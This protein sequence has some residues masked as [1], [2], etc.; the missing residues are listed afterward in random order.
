MRPG[1]SAPA[2][3]GSRPART[4][5]R[6]TPGGSS[7]RTRRGRAPGLRA[8]HQHGEQRPQSLPQGPADSS[9]GGQLPDRVGLGHQG[10][11]LGALAQRHGLVVADERDVYTALASAAFGRSPWTVSDDTPAAFATC[12]IVVVPYPWASRSSRATSTIRRRVVPGLLGAAAVVYVVVDLARTLVTFSNI[13]TGY[14]TKAGDHDTLHRRAGLRPP[15]ATAARPVAVL[16]HG[17]IWSGRTCARSGGRRRRPTGWSRSTPRATAKR[18]AGPGR[19]GGAACDPGASGRRGRALRAASASRA[20]CWSATARGC[21]GHGESLRADRVWPRP[22]PVGRHHVVPQRGA[23]GRRAAARRAAHPPWREAIGGF[24]HQSYL[25]TDDPALLAAEL[26]AVARKP[27]HVVAAVPEQFLEWD[28]EAALRALAAPLLYVDASQMTDV[29]RLAELVPTAAIAR[30]AGWATCSSSRTRGRPS[31]RS[32]TS[33]R[34]TAVRGRHPHARPRPVRGR[35]GRR[36]GPHRRPR[37]AR[38]RRPRRPTRHGAT[39]ARG[40]LDGLPPAEERP[41]DDYTMLDVVAEGESVMAWVRCT[42]RHVGEFAGIPPDGPEFGFDAMHR[43]RVEDGVIREHHAVRDDLALFWQL[44]SCVSV[45]AQDCRVCGAPRPR[46]RT[47]ARARRRSRR[48]G[49]A[50][51]AELC[52]HWEHPPPCPLAPHHTAA[53]RR[54][55]QVHLRI[56]FATE[57]DREA[58]V[59]TRIGRALAAWHVRSCVAG[60]V[61]PDE[62]A[63][64][65]RLVAS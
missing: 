42:G 15:I 63:H 44:G 58:E 64:A 2:P 8:R 52:G 46:R 33:L 41:A 34:P 23:G 10:L 6:R 19:R 59:R 27:Q 22:S 47:G 4:R 26:A 49:G 17:W 16:I 61:R 43:Y 60:E 12:A 55:A 50:I 5:R 7:P 35:A 21:C 31:R 28:A 36:A 56:L 38:L 45:D 24:L 13:D 40:L 11:E 29:D 65:G 51:T 14:R 53:Q 62:R 18:G 57:P 9:V 1:C 37:V 54:V 30:T 39:G 32:R 25:P 20:R 3:P 48:A